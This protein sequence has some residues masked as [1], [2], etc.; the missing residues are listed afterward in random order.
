MATFLD[1]LVSLKK[2][3]KE[4]TI[5]SNFEIIEVQINLLIIPNRRKGGAVR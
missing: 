1:S 5:I 4:I 2:E 3:T